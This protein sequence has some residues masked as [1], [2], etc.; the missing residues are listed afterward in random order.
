ML[1]TVALYYGVLLITV[2]VALLRGGDASAVANAAPGPTR[3]LTLTIASAAAPAQLP[4]T[5]GPS[6][7]VLAGLAAS[8]IAATALLRRARAA[9]L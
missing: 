4:R 9:R 8:L 6:L 3:L 5:G 7:P 2:T 1:W